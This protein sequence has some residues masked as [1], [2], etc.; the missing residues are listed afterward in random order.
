MKVI[1]V[2]LACP[3]LAWRHVDERGTLLAVGGSTGAKSQCT[4][5]KGDLM[6]SRFKPPSATHRVQLRAI[7]WLLTLGAAALCV[8]VSALNS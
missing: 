6:P 2:L 8:L 7:T 3:H 4:R 1:D 5:F